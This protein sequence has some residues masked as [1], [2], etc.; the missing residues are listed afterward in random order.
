[1]RATE[2]SLTL[3]VM[4]HAE[5]AP[6]SA[7]FVR[8]QGPNPPPLPS[9]LRRGIDSKRLPPSGTCQV[10][11]YPFSGRCDRDWRSLIRRRVAGRPRAALSSAARSPRRS[12]DPEIEG[13][14]RELDMRRGSFTLRERGPHARR[15][16]SGF[17]N[18]TFKDQRRSTPTR[19]RTLHAARRQEGVGLKRANG[20]RLIK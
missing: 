6:K 10:G 17:C 13:S 2:P 1:M 5:G 14:T 12:S 15:H 3:P 4:P 9:N 8:N 7:L 16:L 18:S 20:A 11:R 19:S